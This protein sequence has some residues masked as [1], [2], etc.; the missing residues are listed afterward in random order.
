MAILFHAGTTKTGTTSLQ[1]FLA[2]NREA[3]ASKGHVFP[4]FL[5]DSQSSGNHRKLAVYALDVESI[6]PAKIQLSL[7]EP[8]PIRAFRRQL[9]QQFKR[10]IKEDN[11]Y[12]LSSEHCS[13]NI[14]TGPEMSRLHDL[15]KSTGHEVKVIIYFR[16]PCEY[17]ASTYSTLLKIGETHEMRSPTRRVLGRKYNYLNICERW[18]RVF[19]EENLV[20]RVYAREALVEGD[21]RKDFL[22]L[23]GVTSEGLD[24]KDP[25]GER[26]N[27]SLDHVMAGFLREVNKRVPRHV[28]NRINP[29]R[30]DLH[31]ICAQLSDK[32]GILVP[33]EISTA[34][35][36][37]LLEDM[38][39]FNK[40]FLNGESEWP[41]APYRQRGR[42]AIR[43]PDRDEVLDLC[44]KVWEAKMAQLRG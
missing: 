39:E 4:A 41:F 7:T 13:A 16:D 10:D 17:L 6:V 38:K 31:E 29:L 32:E 5:E 1:R 25:A 34:L 3:L 8:G 24:F 27:R 36:E 21:I 30:A 19:G 35:R 12:I 11:N 14:H 2:N 26:A 40:R 9:D 23:V 22:D 28:E 18:A 43:S 37:S 33:E 42:K 20:A 15:L 44:G